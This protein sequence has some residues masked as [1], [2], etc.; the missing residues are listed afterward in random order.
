MCSASID[1]SIEKSSE[2]LNTTEHSQQELPAKFRHLFRRLPKDRL[3]KFTKQLPH[4]KPPLNKTTESIETTTIIT[5]GNDEATHNICL[6]SDSPHYVV[7]IAGTGNVQEFEKYISEDPSK[8]T[9]FNPTGLCA[10]HNAAARNK[11]AI[12]TLVA[13][14]QGDLNIEDKNG[15]TPLHHAVRNNALAAIEFLLEHLVD[16]SKLN[17]QQEA[18]IHTGVIHNQL[19]ALKLLISKR[20]HLVDLPGERKKT[21]LHYAAL[22]DN[23]DAAKILTNNHANI[24]IKSEV[25]SYPVHVA[26]LNSSNR[27]F[28][29]LFETAKLMENGTTE[30][31]NICD[32]EN[33]R[34]LHSSV[35]GGNTEAVEICLNNGGSID[36]QQDDLSTPVH[37]A[38]SQGSIELTKLMFTCQPQLVP[39]VIRMTDVQ[40]MTSLHKAAMGDHLDVIEYLLESGSDIDA[41]DVSKR[42]PLILAALNSSVHAV[43]FLLSKNASLSYRDDAD[44]NLLHVTIMQNL[45]IDTIGTALFKRDNYRILFDQRDTDGFYPIH[46]ASRDGLV[47]V[48]T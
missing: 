5:A 14:Y 38:A 24:Y 31:L 42:T 12:L 29:H 35:I 19:N 34:P 30:L 2:Y 41:R 33:H 45:P 44:R 16:D 6:V 15:W 8:L 17:K 26:A 9:V 18:A 39:K 25:G 27:V 1:T 13:Q 3:L 21:P 22:I 36:D 7:R 37:L 11:V 46:Y 23:V 40:G 43:C 20:P 4:F 32:A 47:N 48:L 28:N 10:A